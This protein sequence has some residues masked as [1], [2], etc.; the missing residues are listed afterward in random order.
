MKHLS[1]LLCL[2][3]L[4]CTDED[5]LVFDG[6][7]DQE[8]RLVSM[9]G[10]D[11]SVAKGAEMEWQETYR[12]GADGTFTKTRT[13]NGE[14]LFGSGRFERA[15]ANNEQL[16]ELA[17]SEANAI[18]GSCLGQ[19]SETLILDDNNARLRSTWL[20]CDGP[21]LIYERVD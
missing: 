10:S 9:S 5:H 14:T 3:I 2:L 13:A 12:F 7:T 16:V 6:N 8:W 11:G 17:Y 21:G 19:E 1:L 18:V 4:S 20:A 15:E